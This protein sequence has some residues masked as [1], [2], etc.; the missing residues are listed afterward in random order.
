M[1]STIPPVGPDERPRIF[2]EAD[3]HDILKR[4]VHFST[5]GGYTCVS[6]VSQWTGN[7]R[8]ARN[9]VSTGGEVRDNNVGVHRNINGA[10]GS[11]QIN[12]TTD[13]ALVAATRR[14]E[15]LATM[16]LEAPNQ[17]LIARLPLE[18]AT[19]PNIFSEATYQL[20]A[21]QRA[22]AAIA[23]IRQAKDAGMSSA[24]YIEV[25][26]V[27]IGL[28][29][30]VGRVRYSAYTQARCSVTVRDPKGTGS[31]WAGVDWYDWQKIDATKLTAIALDKC[32]KS[33]NAVRIE[34]GRYTTI[35]EPQ[36]V[37]DLVGP[38][39]RGRNNVGEAAI[40]RVTNENKYAPG[41][42][43]KSAKDPGF[44]MLGEKVIDERIT[45]TADPMDSELGFPPFERDVN[46]DDGDLFVTPVFHPVTWIE[47]GVLKNLA[48]SRAHRIAGMGR[49]L[50]I[51]NSRSFRMSGGDTSIDE[52]IATTKRGVLVT[53]F[54]QVMQLNFRSQLY[55]GFTRDGIWLIE[56]GKI[57]HPVVNMVFTEAILWALNNVEQLGPPQ[58]TFHPDVA[59]LWYNPQPTI[60]PPLKIKDFSFTSLADAV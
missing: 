32:L 35:L 19:K 34:P 39:F 24:G 36:A 11:V 45:I 38:L 46:Y 59:F 1:T 31:G 23:L 53:R 28:L 20:S 54:D 6:V 22:A 25:A 7:V 55:R 47:Q 17:D 15:R 52:M 14:A 30:T 4:L 26:A 40:E 41:P 21:D 12:D 58:R 33:R 60:V 37:S 3:C 56:N 49:D 57:S 50:G 8:W 48:T 16:E 27:S 44:S 42:F 9:H 10:I 43:F 13:V 51:A 18:P 2:S 5:G 29:D